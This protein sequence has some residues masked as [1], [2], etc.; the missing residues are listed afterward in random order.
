MLTSYSLLLTA[1][2]SH[3]AVADR[4]LPRIGPYL[5]FYLLKVLKLF[6]L[7]SLKNLVLLFCCPF[8]QNAVFEEKLLYE[9]FHVFCFVHVTLTLEEGPGKRRLFKHCYL[10]RFFHR[11]RAIKMLRKAEICFTALLY[12][13]RTLVSLWHRCCA[14]RCSVLYPIMSCTRFC[15]FCNVGSHLDM[16]SDRAHFAQ[17]GAGLKNLSISKRVN[18]KPGMKNP[19]CKT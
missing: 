7:L 6:N 18:E 13:G 8:V 17:Y 10:S 12:Y 9:R 2:R 5:F 4:K 11:F 14:Y 19:E 3:L 15:S 1:L 16:N